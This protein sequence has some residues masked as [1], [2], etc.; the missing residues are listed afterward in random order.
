MEDWQL[1]KTVLLQWIFFLITCLYNP[2][3]VP[4]IQNLVTS[5]CKTAGL[6]LRKLFLSLQVVKTVWFME[7]IG[8]AWTADHVESM[9]SL[10]I[11]DSMGFKSIGKV[12]LFETKEV[13]E[14][15]WSVEQLNPVWPVEQCVFVWSDEQL[16]SGWSVGQ[17]GIEGLAEELA[18]VGSAELQTVASVEQLGTFWLMGS[19]F[20][21]MLLCV[22]KEKSK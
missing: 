6:S 1:S 18:P 8:I 2:H 5:T 16:E 10:G 20:F 22:I 12:E 19:G 4:Q 7:Q 17:L 9:F 14:I 3:H 21:G 15:V 11:D 13:L